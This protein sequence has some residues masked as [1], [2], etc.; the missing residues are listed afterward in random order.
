MRSRFAPAAALAAIYLLW[1]S[2][3]LAIRVAV[4]HIPPFLMASGR[5]LVAAALLGGIAWAFEHPG[6]IRLAEWRRYGVTGVAMFLGGN[7]LLTYGELHV[8]SGMASV[9]IATIPLWMVAI[10]AARGRLRFH[11]SMAL[12]LAGGILGVAI[13][14]GPAAGRPI[15]PLGAGAIVLAAACWAIGSLAAPSED[16]LHGPFTVVAIQMAAGG[17]SLLF[18]AVVSGEAGHFDATTVPVT[19]WAALAWLIVPAGVITFGSFTY[20]LRVVP[21][22]I[23]AP[24]PFVNSVVAVV[25]GWGLL[26]EVVTLRTILGCA[27]V[28]TSAGLIVARTVAGGAPTIRPTSSRHADEAATP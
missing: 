4:I 25:L 10:Q 14:V 15:D 11:P 2:T 9:L 13:L 6:E 1:G 28:L 5:F 18:V 19:A 22:H 24:Y 26:S 21:S 16:A 3:F 23:V 20:A 12:G 17:L 7:G 27:V 8:P